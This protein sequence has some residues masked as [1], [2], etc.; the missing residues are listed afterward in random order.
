MKI[1]NISNRL[2]KLLILKAPSGLSLMELLVVIV[3]IAV[4]LLPLYA[5]FNQ[6]ILAH[7]TAQVMTTSS[8]LG[9]YAM[10]SMLSKDFFELLNELD[11][12]VHSY[13]NDTVF[14]GPFSKYKYTIEVD[15]IDPEY[16]GAGG[17]LADISARVSSADGVASGSYLRIYVRI[18]NDIQPGKQLEL[19]SIVTPAGDGY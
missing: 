2:H 12:D 3:I 4:S 10:E 11:S 18:T 15:A 13:G 6:A 7:V 17:D 5:L 8:Y 16:G 9:Q 1:N 14:A 19:Y